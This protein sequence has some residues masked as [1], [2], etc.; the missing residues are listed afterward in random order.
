MKTYGLRYW[1]DKNLEII[2]NPNN[3]TNDLLN[4][5]DLQQ[6]SV[7]KKKIQFLLFMI[8]LWY[9]IYSG[10]YSTDISLRASRK[11]RS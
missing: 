11:K 9:K 5:S 3:N 8:H 6:H 10:I 2:A 7:R 4:Y 1:R